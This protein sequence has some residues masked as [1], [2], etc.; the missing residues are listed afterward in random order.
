[1]KPVYLVL[2]A[3]TLFPAI[4]QARWKP[5]YASVPQE[6]QDWY[7]SRKLTDAVA[8][9]FAFQSCCD[10]SDKVETQ[11]SVDRESGDDKWYYKKDDQWLEVPT[12]VIWWDEHSP[13]GEAVL[14]AIDG[15]P[16]CFFPPRGGL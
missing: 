13:T 15:K 4:S 10:G 9:R 12:D 5:Q 8:K 14:F 2:A 6:I 1:M 3:A 16:T 11:F 7:K